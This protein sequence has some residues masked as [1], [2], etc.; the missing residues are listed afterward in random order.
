MIRFGT[1]KSTDTVLVRHKHG[2]GDIFFCEWEP[3]RN[4]YVVNGS[5]RKMPIKKLK[6]LIV[7][8]SSIKVL[9]TAD[10]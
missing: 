10:Y 7:V 2:A 1:Y 9:N 8:D 4:I 5:N 3:F 6:L